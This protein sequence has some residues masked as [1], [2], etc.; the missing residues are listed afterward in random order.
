MRVIDVKVGGR[1]VAT[2][3][4]TTEEVRALAGQRSDRFVELE[5]HYAGYEVY[6]RNGEKIG[7]VDVIFVDE[8]DDPEYIGVKTGFLSTKSTL[9]PM[10][11]IR[12]DERRRIVEVSRPKSKVKEGP[13]FDDDK[14]VT[15]EH[16]ERVRSFYG[17]GSLEGS[18]DKGTYGDS[19]DRKRS[20]PGRGEGSERQTGATASDAGGQHSSGLADE[21]ELRMQRIEEELRVGTREREAGRVNVRKRVRT[22]RERIRVPRRREEV[23]VKKMPVEGRKAPKVEIGEE[24]SSVPVTEEETV[25]ET[26]PVVKEEIRLRKDVVED[27]EVVERD[28]RKEEI[29]IDDQTERR[30]SLRRVRIKDEKVRPLPQGAENNTSP[31]EGRELDHHTPRKEQSSKKGQQ[32]RTTTTKATKGGQEG[33]PVEGYDDLSVEE[34][35]KKLGGLSV[36][37]LKEIRSYEKKHKSRKTLV[38]WLDRK[39]KNAS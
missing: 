31:E 9:I 2:A 17:L 26:R 11:A 3:R 15:P 28:V 23:E 39:I 36:G 5:E 1:A 13:A 12:I 19:T 14:E 27:E 20:Y 30:G 32:Q 22:D 25:V 29:D 37:E 24:E 4:N 6:D 10:D 34:A 16:E 33:L 38:E 21:D 18:A 7:N 35:K 8:S